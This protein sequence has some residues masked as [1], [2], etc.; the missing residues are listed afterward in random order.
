M[1]RH[2]LSW[3][4]VGLLCAGVTCA[5]EVEDT[6]KTERTFSVASGAV[7]VA[8]D[9]LSGSIDVE[10][11]QGS[12]VQ[13]VVERRI[14]ASSPE[15]VGQAREEERLEISQNGNSIRL[16]VDGP[17]RRPDGSIHYRG[18]RHYGY[19]STFDFTLRVP[20]RTAVV[21]KTVNNGDVTVRNTA[22]DFDLSNVNGGVRVT[23][24]SGSGRAHT[25]NGRVAVEFAS[26]PQAESYFGSINGDLEVTLP[27]DLS[28]DLRVT[29]FNGQ[30]YTDFDVTGLPQRAFT[31]TK[32]GDKTIY[33]AD[34]FAG[35][36]IGNGGPEIQ[37][38][39]F[40]GDVRI[41]AR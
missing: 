36:R 5:A 27:R 18:W 20:Q 10:G 4:A 12:E 33:R 31:T 6:E 19:E 7:D 41:L 2:Q 8:V 17:C 25:V 34:K 14:R 37:F 3:L 40:N 35:F 29:T 39:T 15:K 21:L 26:S 16:F 11:Y 24:A 28:A 22:G 38:D 13:L 9:S 23:G 30:V 1:R 32:H